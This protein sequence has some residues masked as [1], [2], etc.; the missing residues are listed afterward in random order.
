MPHSEVFLYH[1]VLQNYED[2]S[3]CDAPSSI[4]PAFFSALRMS[5]AFDFGLADLSFAVQCEYNVIGAIWRTKL[6]QEGH[7]R[8]ISGV[9]ADRALEI[10]V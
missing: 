5:S 2:F 9:K 7:I 8:M 4:E 3:S 1:V 10:A 6:L